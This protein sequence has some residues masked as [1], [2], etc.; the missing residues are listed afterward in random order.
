MARG[1]SGT[2]IDT[3]WAGTSYLLACA[4]FQPFIVSLSDIFGRRQILLASVSFFTI[5]TI[6]CCVAQ[7]FSQLFAGRSVQGV[8]GG[9]IT[10]LSLIIVTDIVPLRFRPTYYGLIQVAW[11]VGTMMGPLAG[12][13]FAEHANWRWG[14][15][16]NL[17]FCAIGLCLVPLAVRLQAERGTLMHR[18]VHSVD[19]VGCF[20][21]VGSVS[22]FLIGT[23]WGGQMFPWSSWRTLVP[24]VLGVVGIFGTS[25]WERYGAK[26]PFI[27]LWLLNERSLVAAYICAILQGLMVSDS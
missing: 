2:A 7:D 23:S 18:L 17:P 20:L 27:R 14:F 16:I 1:L 15:Y 24:I 22:S 10:A 11:A 21:F 9:G 5:G 8:G 12:G 26:T 19:W 13:L 4:V 3:F 6:I 25:L